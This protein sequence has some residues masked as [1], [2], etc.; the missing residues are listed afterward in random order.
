MFEVKGFRRPGPE[1]GSYLMVNEEAPEQVR[2][3]DGG[4]AD[5]AYTIISFVAVSFTSG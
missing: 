1:P 3:C 4:C 5:G 2:G